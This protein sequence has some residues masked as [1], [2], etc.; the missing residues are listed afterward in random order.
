L[1]K[2][3]PRTKATVGP[4]EIFAIQSVTE[5]LGV[6]AQVMCAFSRRRPQLEVYRFHTPGPEISE[7]LHLQN[8]PDLSL[9]IFRPRDPNRVATRKRAIVQFNLP[10]RPRH[11]A[12][13]ALALTESP[14]ADSMYRMA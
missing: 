4:K 14:D 3:S 1:H 9:T 8:A 2:P 7:T 13:A 5:V 11:D 10:L 12:T 6:I